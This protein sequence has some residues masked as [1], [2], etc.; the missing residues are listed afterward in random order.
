MR[1]AFLNVT[2]KTQGIDNALNLKNNA[3]NTLKSNL[4]M[5]I[6]LIF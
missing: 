3:L 5:K 2:F 4:N 6:K 1:N